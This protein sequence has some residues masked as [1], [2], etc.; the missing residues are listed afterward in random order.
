MEPA[1]SWTTRKVRGVAIIDLDGDLVADRPPL[2][3]LIREL[4]ARGHSR[5]LVN[6]RGVTNIDVEVAGDLPGSRWIAC[7]RQGELKLLNARKEHM[8]LVWLSFTES[9]ERIQRTGVHEALVDQ[10][11]GSYYF[12]LENYSDEIEAVVSFECPTWDALRAWA[13]EGFDAADSARIAGHLPDCPW[14]RDQLRIMEAAEG[15][16]GRPAEGS[17]EGPTEGPRGR[18]E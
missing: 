2:P 9:R 10:V 8:N 5:F 12:E 18:P 11:S 1:V 14:C 4:L 7:L 6:L 17:R 3:D 13:Q 15:S 16:A